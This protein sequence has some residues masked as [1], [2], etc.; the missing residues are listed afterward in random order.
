VISDGSYNI[1]KDIVFSFPVEIHNKQWKIV[2]DL[3]LD[4]F[5]RS[6]LAITTK[7]L[8]EERE[9]AMAICNAK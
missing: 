3:H 7:E 4:D 6:Q 5:A 9:E 8:L 1:P 2:Q